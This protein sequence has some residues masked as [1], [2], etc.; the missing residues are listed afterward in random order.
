MAKGAALAGRG[1]FG[2]WQC[3]G[4]WWHWAGWWVFWVVAVGWVVGYL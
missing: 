2:W 4:G 3:G 1:I